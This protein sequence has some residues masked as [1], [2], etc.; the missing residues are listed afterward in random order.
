MAIERT[1]VIIKPDG[2]QRQIVGKIIQRF[3]DV[4]LKI[5]GMKMIWMDKEFSRNHYKAHVDKAFYNGLEAFMTEGPVV[6]FVLQGLHAVD[7]IRKMVGPTEP[8][9][10]LPGTIRGDFSHHSYTYTDAKGIAIKN[11]IH[12]SGNEEEAKQEI[13]LWFKNNEIHDYNTVHEKHVF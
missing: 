2:I 5:V 7:L 9:K 4:G 3:E 11:V 13:A 8:H 12:A 1:F 6:A 10:A